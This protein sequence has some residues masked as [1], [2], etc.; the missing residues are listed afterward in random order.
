MKSKKAKK[1]GKKAKCADSSKLIQTRNVWNVCMCPNADAGGG[2]GD[3]GG[4][5]Q[6]PIIIIKKNCDHNTKGGE[7][8]THQVVATSRSSKWCSSVVDKNVSE[9]INP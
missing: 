8:Q 7:C 6:C 1:K 4:R 2:G 3:G 5:W 9:S